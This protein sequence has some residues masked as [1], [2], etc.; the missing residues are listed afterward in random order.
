MRSSS[1]T[2]RPR[3]APRRLQ[4]FNL[5][6]IKNR[7]AELAINTRLIDSRSFAWDLTLSG[8]V[9]DNKM[10]ELGEGVEP[11]FFGFYQRHVA[12]LTPRRVLGA[13]RSSASTT[14]TATGSSPPT[15]VT[16]GRR[17]RSS[18]AAHFPP[19][20]PR[21]TA[22]V[23]LFDGLVRV[24]TQFDYRGG[25]LV[26]NC[27]GVSSAATPVVN[28]RGLVDRT[29]PLEEQ[30]T[31]PGGLLTGGHRRGVSSSRAGSSS[32]GSCR[33]PSSRPTRWA[34]RFRAS[35]LSLTLAGRNLWTITDYSGV[36]PEVNAFAQDNFST[37]DFESQ[38]QV[39]YWTAR[40]NVGF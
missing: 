28:C 2:S 10:L 6:R 9:N 7:G 11:I 22:A 36:D 34:R 15:E 26:D 1:A 20:R 21:S 38:P 39:R 25:H 4:F 19:R 16:V 40:L 3:W 27:H 24:G 33:S 30:A 31:G 14:P 17:A 8:S 37:S 23:T 5:G 29:A 18:G 13:G 12:G 32:C 35:R